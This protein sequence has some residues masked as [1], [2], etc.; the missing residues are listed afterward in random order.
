MQREK[1]EYLPEHNYWEKRNTNEQ[2]IQTECYLDFPKATKSPKLL[3]L[4]NPVHN[5]Y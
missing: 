4:P 1:I 2:Y 5:F 3:Q